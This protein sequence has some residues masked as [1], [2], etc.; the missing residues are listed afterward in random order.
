MAAPLLSR[1]RWSAA[2]DAAAQQPAAN[3]SQA[4]LLSLGALYALEF[5]TAQRQICEAIRREPLN[6]VHEFRRALL[7]ARFGDLAGASARLEKLKEKLP[8]VATLDYLRGLFALRAG[9]VEKAR[10]IAGSIESTHPGFVPGK[11]LRAEAQIVAAAKARVVE[12]YL[13]ALPAGKRWDGLWADL[14]CKLALFHPSEGPELVQK[15]LDKKLGKESPARAL[16]QMALAWSGATARELVEHLAQQ[17]PGSHGEALVLECLGDRL[18]AEKP[19]SALRLLTGLRKSFPERAAVRRLYDATLTQM[20]AELSAA[21]RQEEA[22]RLVERCLRDQPQDTVYYQNR[23]AIFTL[24]REAGPYHEAWAALNAHQYRLALLGSFDSV[25][26]GQIVK[27]HRL[28]AQQ[29]RGGTKEARGVFRVVE[30]DTGEGPRVVTNVDEIAA[31]PDLLRQWIHHS[32]AELVFR[33]ALLGSEGRIVLLDPDDR[34][35]AAARASSLASLCDSLQVLAPQEGAALAGILVERWQ[36][37]AST[38]RTRYQTAKPKAAPAEGESPEDSGD[39]GEQQQAAP[40]AA[41]R[42]PELD[43][44]KEEHLIALADLCLVCYQWRPEYGHF[45]IAEDLLAFTLTEIPFFDDK[46]LAEVLKRH[47]APYSVQVLA[48]QLR[49]ATGPKGPITAEHK[50]RAVENCVAELLRTMALSSYNGH[51][52]EAKDAAGRA[53]EYVDRARALNPTDSM[54]ELTASQLFLAGEF[55]EDCRRALERFRRLAAPEDQ[56]SIEQAD[57]VEE[58]LRERKKEGKAGGKRERVADADRAVQGSQF[59]IKEM[60]LDLDRSPGVFRLYDELVRELALAGRFDE[61][62]QWAD[63]SIAQ[64]LNRADQMNARGLAIEARGMRALAMV[65]PRAARLYAAGAHEPARKALVAVGDSGKMDYA[66]LYLLGRSELAVGLPEEA[67]GRFRNAEQ[68]CERQLHR[69]VLRSLAANVD[70]AYVAVARTA[71]DNALQDGAVG[72]ALEEAAAV[73]QRLQSPELWL[74]DFARV[75][76]SVALSR[77]GAAGGPPPAIQVQTAWQGRLKE[78]LAKE[79]DADRALALAALA[80]EVHPPSAR[81]AQVLAERTR[82]LKRRIAAAQIL[83]RAGT[84]LSAKDFAGAL[85]LLDAESETTA[86]EP[87]LMRIRALALLGLRRFDEADLTVEQIGRGGGT[88][89]RDFVDM[90][91]SLALRQRLALAQELLREG[92]ADEADGLLRNAVAGDRKDQADLAYCR[93]FAGALQGYELRRSGQA[94]AARNRFLSAL[95]MIAPHRDSKGANERHIAELY[96]RLEKEIEYVGR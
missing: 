60:E 65:N 24:L 87:R 23:A 95:R 36:T 25:S 35:E 69:T 1:V 77:T 58:H 17:A 6:P 51:S 47:D 73:F 22:L 34:D 41:P 91:P 92:K 85:S 52:G 20:A 68:I 9:K 46:L 18:R 71:I 74:A 42:M 16:V 7:L 78:A 19:E 44:L 84:L 72:D 90:Y 32:K 11:F 66:L 67:R 8:T 76:Y 43:R 83:N 5:E 54:I 38:V 63:R 26:V 45:W 80:A 56:K 30:D 55:Y 10:G 4:E 2:V 40:T 48:G 53:L 61:A 28:F 13:T 50:K 37:L 94:A 27:A 15:Y 3:L 88:E 81:Q 57:K 70:T 79:T 96:D 49:K 64:C 59:Q 75:Y 31:D 29:A 12:R 39:A 14:F 89:V 93:A 33:H 82:S 86:A 62:I 21:G